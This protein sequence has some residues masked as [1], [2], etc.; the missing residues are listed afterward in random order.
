[1]LEVSVT[2]LRG[3]HGDPFLFLP[4][5]LLIGYDQLFVVSQASLIQTALKDL[6]AQGNH[7]GGIKVCNF[8]AEEIVE[9]FGALV[10]SFDTTSGW[11]S[12]CKNQ[13][14]IC[15]PSTWIE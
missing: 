6:A 9:H 5:M 3:S 14:A 8:F 1:M 7:F 13:R 10:I 2:F 11:V 15:W 4:S 12:T